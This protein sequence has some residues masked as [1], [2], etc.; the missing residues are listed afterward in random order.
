MYY[1][2]W[3][4]KKNHPLEPTRKIVAPINVY[5]YNLHSKPFVIKP[6]KWQ[7]LLYWVRKNSHLEKHEQQP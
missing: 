4:L 3:E 5:I 1:L 7:L 6:T 2:K